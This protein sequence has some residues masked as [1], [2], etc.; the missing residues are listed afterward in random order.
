CDAPKTASSRHQ[1]MTRRAR[2]PR[3][4]N[5]AAIERSKVVVAKMVRSA[6]RHEEI[7]AS[8]FSA[9][10]TLYLDLRV[11]QRGRGTRKGRTVPAHLAPELLEVLRQGVNELADAERIGTR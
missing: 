6:P 2:N 7:H 5:P 4:W 3:C 9:N 10:S 8:V 1:V 11:Y